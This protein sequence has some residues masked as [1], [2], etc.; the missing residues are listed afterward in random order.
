MKKCVLE[1][2]WVRCAMLCLEDSNRRSIDG[3]ICQFIQTN[4][5]RNAEHNMLLKVGVSTISLFLNLKYAT[6][7]SRAGRLPGQIQKAL[8]HLAHDG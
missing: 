8:C 2:V 5:H 7:K 6:A 3:H 1:V 4:D